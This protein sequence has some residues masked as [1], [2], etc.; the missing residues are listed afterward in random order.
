MLGKRF[1]DQLFGRKECCWLEPLI[2][3]R[4]LLYASKT[5]LTVA[6]FLWDLKAFSA[7]DFNGLFL[8]CFMNLDELILKLLK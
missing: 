7:L 3:D 4:V 2:V 1:A 5:T 8:S 6:L